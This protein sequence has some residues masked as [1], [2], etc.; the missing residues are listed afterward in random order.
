MSL[1]YKSTISN[2][3]GLDS[4]SQE[5]TVGSFVLTFTFRYTEA[6]QE[7]IDLME[8]FFETRAKSDP[9]YQDG[10][11]VR[12]YDWYSYY[13]ALISETN[14]ITWLNSDPVLPQSIRRLSSTARKVSLLQTNIAIV[15]SLQEQ[16]ETNKEAVGWMFTMTCP[17]LNT[18]AAKL[19]PGG[20]YHY[21]LDNIS[22]KFEKD[23]SSDV[24]TIGK[25]ELDGTIIYFEDY[26]G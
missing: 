12:D 26:N 6:L 14:L 8:R 9:L 23:S 19:I 16:Y 25:D 5:I 1:Y 17:G 4:F 21:D 20:W 24:S 3:E 11:Y 10:N 18:A 7:Q 15:K 2:P 22:W 13:E